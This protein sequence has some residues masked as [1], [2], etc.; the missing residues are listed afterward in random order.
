MN[1]AKTTKKKI[2]E[3]KVEDIKEFFSE[4][5]KKISSKIILLEIGNNFLNIGVAKSKKNKLYIKKVFSQKLPKEALDKSIPSDPLNFGNFLNQIITENKINTNKIA[6]SLPS[7]ACY[8]R[9]IDIPE[10]IKEDQ[11]INFVENPNSGIQIPISLQNSDFEINLTNLPKQ[12][13]ENKFF[14]KYFL[15]SIP[16]K[17]VDAILESIKIAKLELFRNFNFSN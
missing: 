10:E 2:S 17:N 13:V 12:K 3:Y 8:T 15:T 4:A 16:K 5:L 6:L 14:N 1:S 7:D 11:S 9:L